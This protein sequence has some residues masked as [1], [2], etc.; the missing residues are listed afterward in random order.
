MELIKGLVA[1]LGLLVSVVVRE[2]VL[3]RERAHLERH[4]RLRTELA[5]RT[6]AD[7][8]QVR[9]KVPNTPPLEAWA[10]YRPSSGAHGGRSERTG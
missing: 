10:L 1:S 7:E 9:A 6:V 2:R 5:L 3:E 8:V 4:D